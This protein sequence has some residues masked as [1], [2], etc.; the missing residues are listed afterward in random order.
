MSFSRM[1]ELIDIK[2]NS[3]FSMLNKYVLEN[4]KILPLTLNAEN[5]VTENVQSHEQADS[6]LPKESESFY[7]FMDEK[8]KRTRL[9]ILNEK[10]PIIVYGYD[11]LNGDNLHQQVIKP[12]L[13]Q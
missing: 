8:I 4:V 7:C 1:L 13:F 12:I 11:Y 6:L 10:K 9:E 3:L 5:N 2:S